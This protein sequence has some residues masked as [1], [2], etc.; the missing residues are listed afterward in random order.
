MTI[1]CGATW[2]LFTALVYIVLFLKTCFVIM[3]YKSITLK[4]ILIFSQPRFAEGK[5]I[6]WE[7][8][9]KKFEIGISRNY[10]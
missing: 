10:K 2:T 3:P 9:I 6:S 5:K 8:V 1:E 7:F 4:P